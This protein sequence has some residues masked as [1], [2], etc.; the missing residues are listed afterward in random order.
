MN[1]PSVIMIDDIP[2]KEIDF[3]LKFSTYQRDFVRYLF[4]FDSLQIWNSNPKLIDKDFLCTFHICILLS[5]HRY[6]QRFQVETR[7]LEVFKER[8]KVIVCFFSHWSN[9]R[10]LTIHHS[11]RFDRDKLKRRQRFID[12]IWIYN[13]NNI[14][15]FFT[16]TKPV[17]LNVW[18]PLE[19]SQV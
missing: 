12:Q 14:P 16:R 11:N 8:K 13:N 4:D 15:E 2:M 5:I 3:W 1:K 18:N 17:E 7:S 10:S 6:S 19:T 9:D